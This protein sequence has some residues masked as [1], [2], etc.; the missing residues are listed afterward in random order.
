[1][2]YETD[3][4]RDCQADGS[5]G[6]TDK[7]TDTRSCENAKDKAGSERNAG[8]TSDKVPAETEGREEEEEKEEEGG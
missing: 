8:A 6:Q 2:S 1:M 4:P 5:Y 3:A 7:A